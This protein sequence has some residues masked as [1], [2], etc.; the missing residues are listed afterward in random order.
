LRLADHDLGHQRRA[1]FEN[2]ISLGDAQR[3]S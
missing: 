2:A 1:A 3:S